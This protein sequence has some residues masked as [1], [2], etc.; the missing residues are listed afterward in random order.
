MGV[1]ASEQLRILTSGAA[2]IIPEAEFERKL[3]RSVASGTPLRV[4]LGIDPSTP[5]IHFGHAV[6]LRKLRRFQE[7][8]HIAVLI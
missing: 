6:P 5:D 7:L 8:G 2:A 3:E 1:P 4:K